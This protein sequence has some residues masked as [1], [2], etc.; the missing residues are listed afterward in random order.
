MT[1]AEELK[2]ELA[3]NQAMRCRLLAMATRA[4]PGSPRAESQ[5]LRAVGDQIMA[6]LKALGAVK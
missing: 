1:K 4:K 5:K 6:D 3:I 2:E